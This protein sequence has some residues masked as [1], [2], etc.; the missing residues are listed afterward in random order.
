MK[1]KIPLAHELHPN[2]SFSFHWYLAIV[3]HPAGI[4][5]S[6]NGAIDPGEMPNRMKGKQKTAGPTGLEPSHP[7]LVTFIYFAFNAQVSWIRA[8]IFTL[9]SLGFAHPQAINLISQ[10]LEFEARDR[11]QCTATSNAQGRKA[12]VRGFALTT[13]PP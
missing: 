9:D 2:A 4:K 13:P 6:E 11:L 1:S 10:Y 12:L 8:Y 3:Y 7:P 5:G